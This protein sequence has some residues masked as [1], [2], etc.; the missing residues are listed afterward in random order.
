M[1]SN[2]IL[3][4][5]VR[6]LLLIPFFKKLFCDLCMTFIACCVFLQTVEEFGV[7]MRRYVN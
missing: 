4:F 3:I 1:G 2:L 5:K 7:L 6:E